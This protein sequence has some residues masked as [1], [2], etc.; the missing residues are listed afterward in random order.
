MLGKVCGSVDLIEDMDKGLANAGG[1]Y[2]KFVRQLGFV[3]FAVP[4]TY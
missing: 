1:L 4:D 2:S 3:A